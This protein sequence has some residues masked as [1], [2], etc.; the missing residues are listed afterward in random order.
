MPDD[1]IST[2]QRSAISLNKTVG[3]G[4]LVASIVV[5]LGVVVLSGGV[6]IYQ[7]ILQR[8][9]AALKDEVEKM[10]QDLR[11]PQGP[12]NSNIDQILALDQKLGSLRQLLENH[13]I[14]S[15]VLQLLEGNTLP[16]VR[17][18]TLSLAAEARKID[19]AGEAASY[20]TL[21]EQVRVFESLPEVEAVN[22]SGLSLSDKGILSFKL[23]IIFKPILLRWR[24]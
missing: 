5:C 15:N 18:T 11:D 2:Q 12:S 13:V 22:F 24:G 14:G 10:E 23:S 16:R 9:T 17:Y 3:N 21:A 6:Y 20:L 4:L 7:K 1:L 19:L 8:N